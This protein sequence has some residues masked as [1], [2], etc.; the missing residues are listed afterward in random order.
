MKS[1]IVALAI[2]AAAITG[3]WAQSQAPQT[4]TGTLI[5]NMCFGQGMAH[6]KLTAHTKDCALMPDCIESGYAV[7]TADGTPY[8]LDQKGNTD[9]VAALKD[10]K[11]ASNL[12][13]SVTG[14]VKDG[15]IAVSSITLDE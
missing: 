6:D 13:V 15:A 12:T 4:I 3:A 10:S 1:L 14:T 5:D 11:K 8:K 2:T 9:I 7:V